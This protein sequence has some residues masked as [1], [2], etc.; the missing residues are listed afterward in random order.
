MFIW[1]SLLL[2]NKHRFPTVINQ[3]DTIL[4]TYFQIIFHYEYICKFWGVIF[5]KYAYERNND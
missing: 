1:K 4:Q 3:K 2:Y 5:Q